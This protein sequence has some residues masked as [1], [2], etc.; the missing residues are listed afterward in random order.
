MTKAPPAPPCSE[1]V[2]A[3]SRDRALGGGRA[4]VLG[5]ASFQAAR[6]RSQRRQSGYE[7]EWLSTLTL[8]SPWEKT[9]SLSLSS[10]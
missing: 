10:P 8:P 2:P 9:P 1:A 7:T 4:A 3:L 6:W 5:Q